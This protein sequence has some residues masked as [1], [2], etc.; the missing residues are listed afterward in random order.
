MIVDSH[1]HLR[2]PVAGLETESRRNIY[3]VA[4]QSIDAYLEGFDRNGVDACWVLPLAGFRADAFLLAE[5]EALAEVTARYPGRLFP[6]ATVCPG[7]PEGMIRETIDHA[8]SDLGYVGLKFVQ[9][10]GC[11][12]MLA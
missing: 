12:V 6:F 11:V 1:T 7:W 10:L 4:D 2:V 3:G 5:M 9:H 8:V